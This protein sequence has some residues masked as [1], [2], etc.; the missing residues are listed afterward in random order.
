[1]SDLPMKSESPLPAPQGAALTPAEAVTEHK[2]PRR[3]NPAAKLGIT[4]IVAGLGL[5]AWYPASDHDAPFVTSASVTAFVTQVAPRI[6]GPVTQVFVSDN[7]DVKAGAP[8]FQ[9][10]P[11]TF[12][13]DVEQAKAQLAQIRQTVAASIEAV[14]SA[15][16]Q[17][18]RTLAALRTAE[19]AQ[20]RAQALSKDGLV[21]DAKLSEAQGSYDSAKAA[22]DAAS[23][24]LARL[25]AQ[26]GPAG[27][28][29][30]QLQAA[31]VAQQKAE[32]A[33][34]NTTITAPK[35]GYITNLSLGVG[36]YAAAGQPVMTFIDPNS[37]QVVADFRENQLVNVA[38]G[39]KVQLIFE[40]VP[41]KIFDGHVESV[42]WG[43]N[44]GRTT[45]NG[46]A[47]P[48]TDTRWF[49]P[50]RKIP[51]RIA[52]DAGSELPP[53]VRLGSEASVLVYAK[54]EDNP[55]AVISRFLMNFSALFSGFN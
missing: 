18:N 44:S 17:Y 36:Q 12:E 9:I 8:L 26:A 13:M 4:I 23:A 15:E 37:S 40:A 14:R 25:R 2:P 20:L 34:A 28:Q 55:V 11:S 46:L 52:I 41:G 5:M 38:A 27:D 53:H 39:D 43:I 30:P 32:F 33:L 10:D 1:M 19:E 47:Q 24:D 6:S 48:S 45:V 49:P 51:V 50:A 29:N 54:G 16:A 7:A 22:A 31:V 3:K 21:S 42:A 35:D